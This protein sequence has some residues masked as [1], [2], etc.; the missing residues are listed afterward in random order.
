MITLY[1]HKAIGEQPPQI[2]EI[3]PAYNSFSG[4]VFTS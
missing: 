3:L 4:E 1:V 2:G